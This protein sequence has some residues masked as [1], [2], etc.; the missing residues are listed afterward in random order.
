MYSVEI[1]N[2]GGV[3][4]Y[5]R[6]FNTFQ[7]ATDWSRAMAL[8]EEGFAYKLYDTDTKRVLDSGRNIKSELTEYQKG[9]NVELEHRDLITKMLIEAGQEVTEEKVKAIAREIARAHI[10]EDPSYYE[11]LEKV[12][13]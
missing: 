6:K 9:I 5:S 11:K 4:M 2:A 7:D 13:L 8:S 12:G 10:E 1:E 3:V